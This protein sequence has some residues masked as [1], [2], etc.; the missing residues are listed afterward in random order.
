MRRRLWLWTTLALLLLLAVGV[1]WAT[2]RQAA[3]TGAARP[4]RSASPQTFV[5]IPQR[6]D[7]SSANAPWLAVPPETSQRDDRRPFQFNGRTYY[8]VPL[9]MVH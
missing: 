4:G 9:G 6:P 3:A 8:I 1:R 2:S 5:T 7:P